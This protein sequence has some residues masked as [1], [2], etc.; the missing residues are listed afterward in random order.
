MKEENPQIRDEL[1]VLEKNVGDELLRLSW[2]MEQDVAT[3]C[4]DEEEE[5]VMYED[6]ANMKMMDEELET[7]PIS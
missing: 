3:D 4:D 1:D 6:V 7:L 5:V 2:A